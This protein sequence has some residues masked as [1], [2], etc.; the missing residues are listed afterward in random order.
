MLRTMNAG[1]LGLLLF[2]FV[3]FAAPPIALRPWTDYRVILWTGDSAWQQPEKVPLFFQRLREMGATTGMVHGHADPQPLL[4]NQCPYYVEN[5]VNRGLCLKWNSTVRDWDG[6]VTR[7]AQTRDRAVF[8]REYS[9]WDPAWRAWCSNEVRTL[10]TQHASHAPLAYDLRD[11]LSVTMS[12]NPF[13]YDFSPATLAAFRVWLQREYDGTHPQPRGGES[14]STP[15]AASLPNVGPEL[16]S[17]RTER[18]DMKSG[19]T[20]PLTAALDALNREW[21]TQFA[22]WDEV[23]PFTTDEIKNRMASG[24]ALPRGNPDWQALAALR[25][26]PAEAR[27]VPTRWNLAPWC[28]FRAFLDVTL[29]GI[30]DDLRH[31]AHG[32]DPATPVGIEGTQMPN[33][34]G[35]YDLWR[36]SQALDW[37]E[38]YDIG[39]ARAIFGSF[40]EGKPLLSTISESDANRA[41]RRL[42]H[43]L[44]EGDRGCI[45]W[46]SEDCIDW[47]SPDYALTPKAQALAP[48]LKELTGPLANLFLRATREYDPIAIHYSQPSI[49]VDWLIESTVDG[50]T[51]HR[52]FSSYEA[53]ANRQAALRVR[54]LRDL[55]L[56]GFSP[57]FL[58]T[59]QIERGA[60]L[61][62]GWKALV[63]PGSLALSDAEAQQI[64]AFAAN[65]GGRLAYEGETG[66]FDAHGKLR[67]APVFE[68]RPACTNIADLLGALQP[69]VRMTPAC[70]AVYRYRLGSVLLLGIE[71]ESGE[72]MGEDLKLRGGPPAGGPVTVQ[73]TLPASAHV[74]DLRGPQYLGHAATFALRLDPHQP[75]LV[76]VLDRAVPAATILATLRTP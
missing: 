10:V 40:M 55:R 58:A 24:V 63:L 70:A 13:D 42:W 68:A 31:T 21:E 28:D 22:T 1:W 7:W 17:G 62:G 23:V 11:E 8:V 47:H 36:L 64:R 54:Y 14:A 50:R 57:R 52:R 43:L 45:V 25:W 2:P 41:R 44:L 38:P 48:V 73:V 37:A 19:P 6:F 56:A 35:G 69:P 66:C 12:A 72:Q 61:S 65:K 59:E 5:M 30:L 39:G 29:A 71:L 34:F 49:Q 46:W 67:P 51:W 76:A 27:K 74:Y 32:L 60:L 9:L 4:D 20:E 16:V 18:P 26:D 75:A 3:T 53:Q 33:A 15:S